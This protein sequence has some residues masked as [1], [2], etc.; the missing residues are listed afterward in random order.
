MV[1]I[2]DGP[3]AEQL[4]TIDLA[5]LQRWSHEAYQVTGRHWV[6]FTL[7]PLGSPSPYLGTSTVNSVNSAE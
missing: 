6:T 2:Q 1:Q 7:V 5:L 3:A 4:A